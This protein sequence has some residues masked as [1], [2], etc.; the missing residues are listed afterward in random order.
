MGG[1]CLGPLKR[2]RICSSL[3]D[4]EGMRA[5]REDSEMEAKASERFGAKLPG[6]SGDCPL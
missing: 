5:S 2:V 3:M 4:V 1:G 6:G